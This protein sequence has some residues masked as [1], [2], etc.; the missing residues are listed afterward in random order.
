MDFAILQSDLCLSDV[1]VALHR[2]P[3]SHA[4]VFHGWHLNG[5]GPLP[6]PAA[7]PITVR[8]QGPWSPCTRHMDGAFGLRAEDAA[9]RSFAPRDS[10]RPIRVR[11]R[12]EV[13]PADPALCPLRCNFAE[14]LIRA[15]TNRPARSALSQHAV[16]LPA[17]R[18][19][20]HSIA[21][22][23]ASASPGTESAFFFWGFRPAQNYAPGQAYWNEDEIISGHESPFCRFAVG[24]RT[25][26]KFAARATSFFAGHHRTTGAGPTG[27]ILASAPG[28]SARATPFF[29]FLA[30]TGGSR[31]NFIAI[32]FVFPVRAY[33]RFI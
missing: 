12:R 22:P 9:P 7:T 31:W 21:P 3:S 19:A 33:R 13:R 30:K 25:A 6:P 29:P 10:G 26:C 20:S 8:R 28:F 17:S 2:F 5:V 32:S 16:I 11:T 24:P 23:A 18:F 4:P 15:S 27:L 1:L 14:E